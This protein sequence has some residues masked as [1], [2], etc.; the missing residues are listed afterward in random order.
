M[1]E[2]EL[3]EAERSLIM[4]SIE[5]DWWEHGGSDVFYAAA[6][7]VFEKIGVSVGGEFRD[8]MYGKVKPDGPD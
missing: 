4:R 3:T 8:A 7:G 1:W 2:I 6:R 5:N